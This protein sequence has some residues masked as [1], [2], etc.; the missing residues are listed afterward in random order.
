MTDAYD[1]PFFV[2]ERMTSRAHKTEVWRYL[3]GQHRI[4][5]VRLG[6]PTASHHEGEVVR[7][8]CTYRAATLDMT[9]DALQETANPEGYCEALERPWNCDGRG[10]RIRLDNRLEDRVEMRGRYN[11]D[12]TPKQ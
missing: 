3:L 9:L 12:G 10:G 6:A 7:E 4:K 8:L 1:Q 2:L 11:E 5:L